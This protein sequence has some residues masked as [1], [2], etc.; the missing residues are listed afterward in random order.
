MDKK[1]MK[2]IEDG[3][4]EEYEIIQTFKYNKNFYVVY[5]DN[6]YT[7]NKLNIYAAKYFPFDDSKLEPI[8]TEEEWQIIEYSLKQK[9]RN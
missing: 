8:K 2:I 1:I 9:H 6:A 7:D 4:E 5:T 3:K